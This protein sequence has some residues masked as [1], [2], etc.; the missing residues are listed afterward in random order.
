MPP[1]VLEQT[2]HK[3]EKAGERQPVRVTN[4]TLLGVVLARRHARGAQAKETR[5]NIPHARGKHANSLP[6]GC[7]AR[8][9][10]HRSPKTLITK[11]QEPFT[12][13]ILQRWTFRWGGGGF[14]SETSR[15]QDVHIRN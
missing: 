12:L 3:N 9:Q 6:G 15:P 14:A 7:A 2:T 11:V 13:C 5:T 8:A 10:L 1:L 4:D